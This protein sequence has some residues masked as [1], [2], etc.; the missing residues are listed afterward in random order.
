MPTNATLR[1]SALLGRAALIA[2]T[3]GA[4]GAA[5]AAEEEQPSETIV[6]TGTKFNTEAAPAKASLDTTEPQTIINKSYIEN[7]TPP[8]ADY[9]TILAIVPGMTG[10]DPN[11]PGLSDGGAKNTLRGMSDG[12]FAMQY[13]GIPFGDTNGPTHHNISYFPASTIGS[14]V[15]DRGPGNAGNLGAATYGGTVKLFSQVL[16]DD[17]HAMGSVS[18]GS[19]NTKL[20]VANL[21]TGKLDWLGDTKIMLN[22]QT[23]GSDGALSLQDVR[24]KNFLFKSETPVGANWKVTLFADYSYL[25]E[26][27]DDN[28]GL[29]PAQIVAFGKDYALQNSDPTQPTFQSYNWTNKETDMD[30]IRVQGEITRT[31]RLDNAAY[32]YAYW[33]HTFSP[34]AQTQECPTAT[35]FCP[36]SA[37]SNDDTVGKNKWFYITPGT[38]LIS[39]NAAPSTDLLAYDK[40]NEY[41]VFGD[42]LRLSQDYDLGWVSGEIRTGV[43]LE[44]Q[45]THRYKYMFDMTDCA[46]KDVD[47]WNVGLSQAALMCGVG[48]AATAT[49]TQLP[50]GIPMGSKYAPNGALGYAKDDEYSGWQ[51]Y[52]PF[53]EVDIKPIEAL[54]I[55]PGV[56]YVHFNHDVNAQVAQGSLCGVSVAC[57]GFNQLG[58]SFTQ[59]FV[60]TDTLPFLTVNYKI[61]SNWS[62][63]GEFAKGIYVPD[64]SAFENSSPVK[65]GSFPNPETTTNYQLGTVFYADNFTFDADFYMIG[66]NNNF[67][68]AT[69]NQGDTYYVN[70]GRALYKGLEG[71]GTYAFDKIGN[72]D[73]SGLSVFANGALMDS[74]A[75][76]GPSVPGN[77]PEIYAGKWLPNAPRW[78]IAGGIMFKRDDWKVAL[79]DKLIGAQYADQMNNDTGRLPSYNNLNLTAGYTFGFAEASINIDNLLNSRAI[80]NISGGD[81]KDANGGK[82]VGAFGPTS[83]SQYFYQ[84]PRSVMGTLKVKF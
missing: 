45:T 29:T 39:K 18:Y 30:Y 46:S 40:V 14:A 20:E 22:L 81:A 75:A 83:L 50:G 43:W 51:Q 54:T 12:N 26:H 3:V 55:T 41:R 47:P 10:G 23:L 6:V 64:V 74:R 65:S 36:A 79:I 71:E 9:V 5:L 24:E 16:S 35:S 76:G 78:T 66:V 32:T 17:P 1:K 33:N 56:K 44:E 84:A 25:K 8:T 42:V 34:N 59:S 67:I 82:Q 21:Q 58:Q 62:V 4:A 13:D 38:G 7:F 15:V 61:L 11:G 73:L 77:N 37:L 2:L 27:L 69:D 52:Q 63:Y 72:T 53:L 60:T 31:T 68:T 57:P 19:F 70:A 49:S 28:N 80:I 48:P